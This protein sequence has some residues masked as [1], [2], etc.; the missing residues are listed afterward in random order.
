M[1]ECN[2]NKNFVLQRPIEFQQ[3]ERNNRQCEEIAKLQSCR[4]SHTVENIMMDNNAQSRG[5]G[6]VG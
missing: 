5:N 2:K 3:Q 6:E 4:L 1:A